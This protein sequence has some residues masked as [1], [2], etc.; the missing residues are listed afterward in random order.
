MTILQY[1]LASISR[2][3]TKLLKI[4]LYQQNMTR[5]K[6]VIEDE[7]NEDHE[8]SW[9][10]RSHP[11][12]HYTF[13]IEN[14]S[15]LSDAK[16][17]CF[18]SADFEAGSYNWKLCV[19]PG[20]NKKKNG[21]GY[22]SLYLVLSKS[23]QLAFNQEVNVTFKL[24]VYDY[25]RN[26]YWNLQDET[27]RRFCGIRSKWGFDKLLSLTHFKNKS[28]GY[29]MEDCCIFGAEIFVIK[30]ASKGECLSMVKTPAYNTYTWT[31]ENFSKLDSLE[32]TNSKVFAIG[33][34]KWSIILYPKGGSRA[35]GKSISL[36][37]K[38]EDHASFEHGRKLYAEFTLRV[39]NHPLIKHHELAGHSQF[40]SSSNVWGF[41]SFMPLIDLND[42]TK[43]FIHNNT[44][45]VEVEIQAM[46]VIKGL[47]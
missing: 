7:S 6:Q 26:K 28:N 23:N 24:F 30:N 4:D 10:L 17:E 16:A 42:T 1:K 32:L 18:H 21:G 13:K 38:L 43:G 31:I 44:L 47:S 19:Y 36:F 27:V 11:P 34:S 41:P 33:G 29:L 14:F 25:I 37:L 5:R 12:A 45:M 20:G 46:T 3:I 8:I 35:K 40:D 22:I 2:R 15:L 9:K 39:R